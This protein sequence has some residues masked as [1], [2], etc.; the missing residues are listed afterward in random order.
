M[1]TRKAFWQGVG[2]SLPFLLVVAPFSTLFGVV[3]TDA[4]LSL[5]QAMGFSV[6]VIAGA[7]Q[8]AALQMMVDNAP[9]AMVL[10][11]SLAVN[12]RMAMY[13]A[14]L[15][16]Y[17]GKAPLWQRALVAYLNFDQSYAVGVSRYEDEPD[18]PVPAR[19]GFFFGIALPIATLWCIM[20]FVGIVLGAAIPASFG[21]DFALPIAFLALIAPMLRTVAHLVAAMVSIVAA[22]VLAWL[23]SGVGLLIAAALAMCA[24]A[25][26]ESWMERRGA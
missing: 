5:A 18:M 19:V 13:S 1:T 17:L 12:L 3:A 20:S 14:S 6:L 25:A 9:V 22:L 24:G 10:L 16:P 23:P 26:V 15:A 21:L 2:R 4:G 7:A 8:F 11:A